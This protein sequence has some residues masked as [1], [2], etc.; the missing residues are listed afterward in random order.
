MS[1]DA[2][3]EMDCGG[4]EKLT[5]ADIGNMTSNVSGMWSDALGFSLSELEG[6]TAGEVIKPLRSAIAKLSDPANKEKYSAMEPKNGWGDLAG[7]C[8]YLRG[9]LEACEEAPLGTLRISY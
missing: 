2:W 7:A 8:D 5:V 3:I 4:P 6:K 9:I 1:Y